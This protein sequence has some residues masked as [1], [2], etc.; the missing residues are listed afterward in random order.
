M[1]YLRNSIR[2]R[3]RKKQKVKCKMRLIIFISEEL[4]YISYFLTFKIFINKRIY[5]LISFIIV[6]NNIK[7]NPNPNYT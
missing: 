2:E 3:E 6:Y 7:S 4:Y 1:N 5:G